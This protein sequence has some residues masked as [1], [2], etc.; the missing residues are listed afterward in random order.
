MRIGQQVSHAKFG[1]G[2]VT[3]VEGAGDHARAQVNFEFTGSKWLVLNYAN[4]TM[5]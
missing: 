4:L 5:L 1:K 2:V 3:D